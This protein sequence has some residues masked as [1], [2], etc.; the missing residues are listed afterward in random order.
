MAVRALTVGEARVCV[1]RPHEAGAAQAKPR[2]NSLAMRSR[3]CNLRIRP[4]DPGVA[5][6][7][8]FESIV[9][10]RPTRRAERGGEFLGRNDCLHSSNYELHNED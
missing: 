4:T 7:S 2:R 8:E 10:D 9:A 6:L 1:S 5:I 3:K